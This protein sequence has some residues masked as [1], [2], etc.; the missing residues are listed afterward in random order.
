MEKLKLIE[1]CWELDLDKVNEGFLFDNIICHVET[2]NQAKVK[3]L[4]EAVWRGAVSNRTDEDFTYLDIPIKRYKLGDKFL[5]ED[6]PMTKWEIEQVLKRRQEDTEFDKLLA[7]PT[8]EYCY[9]I[10]RGLYYGPNSCGYTAIRE[11]A[12]VYTIEYGVSS[13]K[14]CR[15][16]RLKVIDIDE[17]NKYLREASEDILD[18]IIKKSRI[19][20]EEDLLIH[21]LKNTTLNIMMNYPKI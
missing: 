14:S 5:F 7:D 20:T 1:R 9:I 10:K 13:A 16:L 3:L 4:E 21:R 2:R 18:K 17:H 8:I 6:R 11:R 12:G 19:P 15:E